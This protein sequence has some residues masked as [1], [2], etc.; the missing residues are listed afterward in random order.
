[1]AWTELWLEVARSLGSIG[2]AVPALLI[3]FLL[4]DRSPGPQGWEERRDKMFLLVYRA[5]VCLMLAA[6]VIKDVLM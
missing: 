6:L 5:S 2:I 1:M 4:T 3:L